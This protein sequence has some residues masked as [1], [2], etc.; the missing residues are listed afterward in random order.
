MCCKHVMLAAKKQSSYISQKREK[1]KKDHNFTSSAVITFQ[2]LSIHSS[3][4]MY[5]PK[6]INFVCKTYPLDERLQIK[7]KTH[8]I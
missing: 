4:R 3:C 8:E 6:I 2:R 1:K 7:T 5:S